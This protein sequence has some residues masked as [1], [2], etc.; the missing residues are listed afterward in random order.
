MPVWSLRI[1]GLR[2][3]CSLC[4]GER[5]QQIPAFVLQTNVSIDLG[6]VRTVTNWLNAVGFI[7][8]EICTTLIAGQLYV[9]HKF[10]LSP[11]KEMVGHLTFR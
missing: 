6:K 5:S 7:G 1:Q 4:C 3:S 2:G 10:L 11:E 8:I 9:K